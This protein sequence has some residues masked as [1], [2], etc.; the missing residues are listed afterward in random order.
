MDSPDTLSHKCRGNNGHGILICPDPNEVGQ[1]L[2]RLLLPVAKYAQLSYK[3][4]TQ[5]LAGGLVTHVLLEDE[6][7]KQRVVK[8][9]KGGN[10]V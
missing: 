10:K 6:R 5:L 3:G 2:F 4:A 1:I 9:F 8:K 7:V